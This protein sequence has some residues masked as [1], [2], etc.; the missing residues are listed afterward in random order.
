[1]ETRTITVYTFDELPEDAKARALS[2]L[3][4]VNVDYDWWQSTYETI[5]TAGSCLGIDCTIEGFDLHHGTIDLRGTYSYRKGWRAALR[6]EFGGDFGK[7]LERIGADMQN[8]QR[9]LFYRATAALERPYYGRE[10]TAYSAD[11][12]C[13]DIIEPLRDFEHEALRLLRDEWEYLTSEEAII[14][15]IE[16]NKYD[17][18]ENGNLA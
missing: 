18:D 9:R 8:A 2:T 12:G 13:D 4:D 6:A 3:A 11:N 1:M 15:A 7:R 14:E 5:Q 17:F 16:A 10:G